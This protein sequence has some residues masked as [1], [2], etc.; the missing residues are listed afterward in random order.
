M[1]RLPPGH[2]PHS[3]TTGRRD[4]AFDRPA[5]QP[6]GSSGPTVARGAPQGNYVHPLLE[7]LEA[8]RYPAWLF[9][10]A[11]PTPSKVCT[12]MHVKC[13]RW[14]RVDAV[15]FSACSRANVSTRTQHC[16]FRP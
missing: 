15:L 16:F 8:L 9:K 3:L 5:A 2:A 10:A 14:F 13:W 6:G 1:I 7:Q 4:V 11:E 12:M